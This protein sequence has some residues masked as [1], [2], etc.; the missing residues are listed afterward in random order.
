MPV[1]ST[2]LQEIVI[3]ALSSYPTLF[4]L[5]I[6]I[7]F[8]IPFP[9]DI[10]VMTAG[11]QVGE[12]ALRFLP[13]TLACGFGM[14]IR[15]VNAF[16]VAHRYREVLIKNPRVL[17]FLGERTIRR[18]ERVFDKY[19]GL[20]IFMIRFA[21]GTRVKLLFI[22]AAL[23]VRRR[24][25]LLFDFLG[26]LVVAPLLVWLGIRFGDPLIEGV[27]KAGPVLTASLLAVIVALVWFQLKRRKAED[28]AFE[29]S[30]VEESRDS[31]DLESD[32][33]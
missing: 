28:A 13:T 22:A 6:F 18:W 14:Y 10:I 19:G 1:V 21:V 11:T 27:K 3:S 29:A 30:L 33:D 12:G 5:C 8:P 16:M 31:L 17:K 24:T 9:E 7:G 25:F 2:V 4:A 32:G 20:G 15:D 26:M 23:G